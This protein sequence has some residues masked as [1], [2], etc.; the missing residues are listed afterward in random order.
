MSLA[1]AL[2]AFSAALFDREMSARI[3]TVLDGGDS[4]KLPGR[5]DSPKSIPQQAAQPTA[6]AP[7]EPKAKQSPA[8]TLLAALQRES[9]LIDLVQ[10]DIAPFS[11][12]QVGA[13]ARPC[14]LQAASTLNRMF[15]IEPLTTNAD[16]ESMTI[17]EHASASRVQWIGEGSGNSGTLVHHGW[18]ATQVEL[19]EW[20][21]N[22]DDATIIAPLQI[23]R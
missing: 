9:R 7:V 23:Q 14:L 4:T 20:T 12:A 8:I 19:P 16:G 11:D 21:G 6:A 13:A 18:Q 17:D 2:R 22:E 10:E 15:K 5:V 1:I 3:A